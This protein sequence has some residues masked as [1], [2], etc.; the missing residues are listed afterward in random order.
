MP[1][2]VS[3]TYCYRIEWEVRDIGGMPQ[4]D[5]Y[6]FVGLI[7]WPGTPAILGVFDHMYHAVRRG[8]AAWLA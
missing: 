2:T 4:L 3:E 5:T 8:R 6:T 1:P 7:P